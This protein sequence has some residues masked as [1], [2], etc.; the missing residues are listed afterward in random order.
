MIDC[1]SDEKLN[2]LL[3]KHS[4]GNE[5]LRKTVNLWIDYSSNEI[6]IRSGPKAVDL[7]QDFAIKSSEGCIVLALIFFELFFEFGEFPRKSI[8]DEKLI[9]KFYD[10][11]NTL[12]E[13]EKEVVDWFLLEV[14][15][16]S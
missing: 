15:R 13:D 16:N 9:E 11:S 14:G 4:D 7:F 2:I 12:T 10:V 6:D 8:I 3:L 1:I 5:H